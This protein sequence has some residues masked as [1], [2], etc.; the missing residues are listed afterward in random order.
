MLLCIQNTIPHR[1]GLP[2]SDTS[3]SKPAR[4]SPKIFAACHVLH[5]LLAPRHPPDA[6]LLLK[7]SGSHRKA[8]HR[9][10]PT[11]CQSPVPSRQLSEKNDNEDHRR[12]RRM[13]RLHTHTFPHPRAHATPLS[14]KSPD[15]GETSPTDGLRPPSRPMRPRTQQNLIH[16]QQRTHKP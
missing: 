8:S 1:G 11:A 4:G 15:I 10:H 7:T 2:H 6:L 12:R 16:N 13:D 5:R 3:G 9:T 14:H